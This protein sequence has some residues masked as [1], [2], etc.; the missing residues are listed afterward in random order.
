MTC[1]YNSKNFRN[2][3]GL[4]SAPLMNTRIRV[5]DVCMIHNLGYENN[6][7]QK[8]RPGLIL[9][10]DGKWAYYLKCTSV[11][12]DKIEQVRIGDLIS[13]GLT[14]DTYVVLEV[15]RVERSQVKYCLGHLCKEDLDYIK[16]NLT[17]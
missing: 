6:P 14:K 7:G 10:Y 17:C 12:S 15:K 13:A 4:K 1:F 9:G 5:G 2:I 11:R 16:K 3:K 8:S